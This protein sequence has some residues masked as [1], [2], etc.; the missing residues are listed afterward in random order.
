MKVETIEELLRGILK[1]EIVLPDFQRSFVWDAEDV[2]DLLV[3]VCSEYFIGSILAMDST[4]E[5][6]SFKLRLFEGVEKVNPKVEIQKIVKIILDGQQ[7]ATAL[8]YAVF[9]P[10]IPL[11][12][13]KSPY[14]FYLDIE[15]ALDEDWDEAV[16]AVSMGNI[17]D[18]S[19]FSARLSKKEVIT[20]KDL[21]DDKVSLIPYSKRQDGSIDE[22]KLNRLMNI[23]NKFK[24]Y[25]LHIV[26]IDYKDD[27]EKIVETF[28]RI[29]RTG[30]PLSIF[31]LL[32]A[33]LYK[34]D[35]KLRDLMAEAEDE[36]EFPKDVDPQAILRVIT[37]MRGSEPKR[38][39]ILNLDHR[40][41]ET[42]FWE[43]CEFIEKAYIRLKDIKNG[44][45]VLSFKKWIPYSSM[46]VPLAV[47]LREIKKRGDKASYYE[48]LDKWYWASVFTQR[49]DSAVDSKSFMDCREFV[50]WLDLDKEPSFI[51]DFRIENVDLE[52]KQQTNAIYRGII[53]LI[54]L[55]GAMDFIAGQPPQFDPNRVQDDHIFPKKHF[56]EDMILNRTVITSNQ[57][58]IDK[59]PSEFFG[60]R[61]K[62]FGRE[63]LVEIL[64]SHLI[65]EE[66][67]D[68]LLKDDL[69][70]FLECRK[71]AILEEIR[72]RIGK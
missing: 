68:Y 38:K 67:L 24:G 28:E 6:C 69:K 25:K 62:D 43:A 17:P 3:S 66:A 49:Y 12:G 22:E 10:E 23:R 5:G 46:I 15:K 14:I 65:P 70:N 21:W 41:F 9:Q 42:D 34:H 57:S 53:A 59:K 58:K 54:V 27:L 47:M 40:N 60:D 63:K 8:F 45:G 37:L 51:K 32:T 56:K 20:F 11:R 64:R 35:I 16:K 52:V 39:N 72:L 61:L 2:R 7:R 71:K 31:D 44:Y 26:D 55:K 4:E 1:G 18:F 48:K 13:R 30:V 33:K 29:N 19:E 50:F 36:Y